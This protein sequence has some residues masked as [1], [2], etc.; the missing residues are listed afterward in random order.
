VTL[1]GVLGQDAAVDALSRALRSGKV[2]HAYRFEGPDGVGKE[3]A[4]FGLAQALQ[5]VAGDVLGCGDCSGCKRVVQLTSAPPHVPQHPDVVVLE[6]GLYTAEQ[7]G[8][9]SAVSASQIT[10][11]QVRRL[12]LTT[13]AYPPHED[14]A[15]VFIIRRA[16]ELN[17]SSANALLKTLE[18]PPARTH[19]VLITS[20]PDLLLPTIRSRTLP[21][22]FG[23]L[24]D[25]VM[26]QLLYDRGVDPSRALDAIELAGGS[27]SA[28]LEHADD[29]RAESRGAFARAMLEALHAPTLGPAI[30]LAES[31]DKK[32]DV[33]QHHLLGF[34]TSLARLAR[35][36]ASESPDDAARLAESFERIFEA[37]RQ[38]EQTNTQ[39]S[40]LLLDMLIELRRGELARLV[41]S[42][43][44]F[45]PL[46]SGPS[47]QPR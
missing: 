44:V 45:D 29:E 31:A 34:A 22:R 30:G 4:A 39:L 28:A 13:L 11:D 19:F 43:D 21:I 10:V 36:M 7:L 3:L 24:P 26:S 38:L 16:E 35:A 14:R 18:E 47:S 41:P 37:S 42:V 8:A 33:V 9:K 5:C 25:E 32:R 2:H 40:L 17:T 1:K 23:P 20:R 6:A 27:L 12:V 15:R 46:R